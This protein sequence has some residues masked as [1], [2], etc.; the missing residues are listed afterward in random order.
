MCVWIDWVNDYKM[1]KKL[2]RL[3]RKLSMKSD[4]NVYRTDLLST[5]EF[6]ITESCGLLSTCTQE[7]IFWNSTVEEKAV[8]SRTNSIKHEEEG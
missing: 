6:F 5:N 2:Q 4:L 1:W 3:S 8:Q 7:R